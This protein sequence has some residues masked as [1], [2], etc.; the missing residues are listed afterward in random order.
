MEWQHVIIHVDLDCFFAS[1]HIKHHPFLKG[2]PVIIGADPSNGRGRGVVSTC[3]YEA[4]KFGLHSA[5]PISQAHKLC[6]DGIYICSGHQIGFS[7]YHEESE[8]VMTILEKYSNKFQP[9]G[10]DEAY[11]D[12]TK[13]WRNYGETPY[14]IAKEIQTSIRENLSLPVSIGVAETKS[15]A[16][17][18]S[19]LEKPEGISVVHNSELNSKIYYLPVRKIIGVGKK[20]EERMNKLGIKTIG[21]IN[22]ITEQKLYNLFGTYGLYLKKVVSGQNFKEVGIIRGERKSISSERTFS[23]DQQDWKVINIKVKELIGKL[24]HQLHNYDLVTRTVSIKIRFQGFETYT[25]SFSYQNHHAD[26]KVILHT[27]LSLLQEFHSKTKKI[28]LIGVRVSS[29][30]NNRRQM[31]LTIFFN[32]KG[33]ENSK[34]KYSLDI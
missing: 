2:Y 11:L 19:D 32:Y 15:I 4:R 23:M 13:N 14:A 18:A 21:D 33:R 25:R 6:P 7:N 20:S 8:K 27:A 22:D 9:A 3:S 16:K 1:V 30:K 31:P 28:R 12:V 17:I 10:I 24:V 34:E 26:E 5:M 29:L